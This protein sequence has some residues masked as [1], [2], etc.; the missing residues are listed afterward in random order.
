M[1]CI[2]CGVELADS[3]KKCPLCG[4]IVYHPEIKQPESHG[5]FPQFEAP[6]E[7]FR[8]DGIIF[9]L[10]FLF[11]VPMFLTLICDFSLHHAITWSGYAVNSLMLAYIVI[12]LPLWFRTPDAVVCVS[13]DYV[14]V[15]LFLLYVNNR[16]DGS[17][18]LPFALPVTAMAATITL[19]AI[20][21][22]KYL[23]R[24][25]LFIF[26]GELILCGGFMVVTEWLLNLTFH[27]RRH[28][29]WS[30]YPLSIFVLLGMMLLIIAVCPPLRESLKKKFFI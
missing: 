2:K 28:L 17:W 20:I 27:L 3:E 6:K 10:S 30:F 18:F 15:S 23:K 12:V 7:E 16:V 21:L 9:I 25:R 4:T 24:G 14:G 19:S 29:V 1:Y 26:G 13:I 5:T 8:H 22:T 11:A